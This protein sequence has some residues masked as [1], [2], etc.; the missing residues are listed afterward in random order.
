[1]KSCRTEHP[2]NGNNKF[3]LNLTNKLIRKKGYLHSSLIRV[4]SILPLVDFLNTTPQ[5]H[6]PPSLTVGGNGQMVESPYPLP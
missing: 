4:W 5:R 6:V 2:P 3:N 1:M